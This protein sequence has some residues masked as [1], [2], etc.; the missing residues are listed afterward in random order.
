MARNASPRDEAGDACTVSGRCVS[1]AP[2]SGGNG[3]RSAV[4]T[5]VRHKVYE[6][7]VKA[8]QEHKWL[9]SE[10]AGRDVGSEAAQDWNRRYWLRFYR[11]RFVQHLR[12]E[13]FFEEF[14]VECYRLVT[15]SI[16]ASREV[17]DTVLDKVQEGAENLELICWARRHRL[18]Q[19]QVLEILKTLNINSRRLPPPRIE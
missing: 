6:Q 13:A 5:P 10:K 8:I 15:G 3:R 4:R 18:P 2:F 12:G 7:A 17:L 14:G 9:Q 11:E 19:D 16:A 1:S